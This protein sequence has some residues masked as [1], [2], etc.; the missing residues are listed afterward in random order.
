M[1]QDFFFWL[2]DGVGLAWFAV[3]LWR[4]L[5]FSGPTTASNF[6]EN[7]LER[8]SNGFYA[9]LRFQSENCPIIDCKLMLKDW[10]HEHWLAISLFSNLT[11]GYL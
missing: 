5:I 4:W 2:R 11:V 3:R 8:L 6:F 10:A 1:N 7:Q 9:P